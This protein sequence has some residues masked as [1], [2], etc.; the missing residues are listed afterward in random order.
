MKT[1]KNIIVLVLL[2]MFFLSC[3]PTYSP[4]IYNR[5]VELKS[6]A[7][8]LMDNATKPYDKYAARSEDLKAKINDIV[9]ME[10]KRKF[11]KVKKHQWDLMT[12]TTSHL[13]FGFLNKWKKDTTLNYNFIKLEKDIVRESFDDII[14]TEK[15]LK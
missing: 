8:Y 5:T 15:T 9:N 6:K 12:D 7:S 10:K 13:L 3:A 1:N 4:Y 11:N 14:Q 2:G